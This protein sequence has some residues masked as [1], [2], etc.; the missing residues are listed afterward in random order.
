VRKLLILALL[1][2][3]ALFAADP[4]AQ[5]YDNQVSSIER[6]VLRLAQAMP[7]DKYNFAPTTGTFTGVRTFGKQV[8][9]I[10]TYLYMLSSAILVE[11]PPVDI[12]ST[13]NGPDALQTKD[14]IVDYLKG[15][16]A[17]AHK[18]V[19]TLTAN[20]QLE[21]VNLPGNERPRPRIAAA[22]MISWHT[23]DHYGQMVVYARMNGVVPGQPA[24]ASA[25]R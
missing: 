24:P 22:N 21:S 25:S 17:Y 13:D 20:N 3:P 9:H 5:I 7:A 6:D 2:G 8:K 16:I 18:A 19:A 15:S 10:A 12:G 14:Q 23:F 4:L 11:K 1:A